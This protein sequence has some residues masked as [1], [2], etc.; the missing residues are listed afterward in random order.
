MNSAFIGVAVGMVLVFAILAAAASAAT[1]LI[2]RVIGLRGEYLLRGLR[3]LVDQKPGGQEFK[4]HLVLSSA[5]RSARQAPSDDILRTLVEH[6]LIQAQGQKG[7]VYNLAGNAPLTPKERRQLPS[8]I[9]ARTFA[10]AVIDMVIPDKAGVTTMDTVK[11]GIAELPTSRLKDVL[12]GLAAQ[13]EGDISRFRTSVETWYDD[14][15]AR[16]SGWYKRH[17]RWISLAAAAVLV[18]LFNLSAVRI[19][20]A[21]YLDEP[22]RQA[23]VSQAEKATG[24]DSADPTG[25][26]KQTREDIAAIEQAGMPI[27][28]STSV[29]CAPAVPCTWTDRYGI[30]DPGRD[31]W[32]N[33]LHVL[34]ALLGYALMVAATLPGARFWFAALNR[35]NVFRSS[36]PKPSSTA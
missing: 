18:V 11:D 25:C 35:L 7:C 26:L 36:G 34:L 32:H 31:G 6:P 21:L 9:S 10:A 4:T 5:A 29:Q 8:Y 19:A 20:S 13:A 2:A 16:V 3:T 17:V 14:H 15:M 1:E 24:C 30:T 22:L 28:W 33:T 27:G 12:S 23:V